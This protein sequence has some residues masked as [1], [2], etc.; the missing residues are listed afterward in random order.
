MAWHATTFAILSGCALADLGV[1]DTTP[2]ERCVGLQN[3]AQ[4]TGGVVCYSDVT[5]GSLAVYFC[6]STHHLEGPNARVMETG[7]VPLHSVLLDS[8]V[9]ILSCNHNSGYNMQ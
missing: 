4:F 8:H 3:S 6:N 7:V 9:C 2:D 5:P 1:V